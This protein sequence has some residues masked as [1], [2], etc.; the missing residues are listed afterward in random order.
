[1]SKPIKYVATVDG[2]PEVT[3]R[4]TADFAFW[5]SR[6]ADYELEPADHNGRARILV[7]AASMRY[8]GM[9][10]T[11]VSFSVEVVSPD[12]CEQP[13]AGFLIH[14]FNTS[15]MFAFTERVAFGT[16]YYHAD[17]RISSVAPVSIEVAEGG[18]AIFHATMNSDA[19]AAATSRVPAR[20]G[21]E[22]WE[23]P[24]FLPRKPGATSNQH[25]VF[26][27]KL[28]GDASIYPYRCELDSI[29]I[30]PSRTDALSKNLIDSGFAGE[31]WQIRQAGTHA[32]SKTYPRK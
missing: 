28:H 17:C 1:M 21:M 26:F 2:V 9:R 24:I 4:G 15:R 32:R 14:A 22:L 5:Q 12:Q 6:L 19:A 27:G 25:Y 11:E 23:G 18:H 13:D 29:S 10:F 16:P 3:L 7:I 30:V 20:N 31:E 8:M